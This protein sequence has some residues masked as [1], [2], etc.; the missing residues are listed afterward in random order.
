MQI[1]FQDP[2]GSL[3]PRM[4]VSDIIGEGLLAQADKENRWGNRKVRDERVGDYLE[5]VGLR[6]DY[7]R[8]YPARVLAAASASASASRGRSRWSPSSSSATSRCPR[9]T[10]R[11][12]RR[13]S[14]CCWTCGA[15]ST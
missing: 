8:R 1:I 4:P 14:T 9:S 5:V 6:R 10:C 7:A 2:V 13:S 11:S 12:S 15:S 3:N